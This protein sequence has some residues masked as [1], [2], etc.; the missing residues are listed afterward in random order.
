MGKYA[1]EELEREFRRYIEIGAVGEDWEAWAN[2]F[3]EDC[4]YHERVLGSMHGREAV[5]QWIVAIMQEFRAIYT[6]YEWHLVDPE[7]GRV[8]FYMQNRRDHPSGE[9]VIDFP[10]IT[11]LEYAGDGLWSLEEDYWAIRE[12]RKCLKLY[13]DACEK[14]DPDHNRKG[15]RHDWGNGPAWAR[16]AP[17]YAER[18]PV[19]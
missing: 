9:G 19:G 4:V 1:R 8:V 11:I 3:S 2:L 5:K 7:N 15:T 17:S 14:W 18:K 12:S 10:G 13:A 16:G 6:V